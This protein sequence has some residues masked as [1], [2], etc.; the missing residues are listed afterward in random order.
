MDTSTGEKGH[1]EVLQ[2][3][4]CRGRNRPSLTN[5]NRLKRTTALNMYV[6]HDGLLGGVDQKSNTRDIIGT[7]RR[8]ETTPVPGVHTGVVFRTNSGTKKQ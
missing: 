8:S 7:W 6:Q 2:P 4:V 3:L 1:A 5:F